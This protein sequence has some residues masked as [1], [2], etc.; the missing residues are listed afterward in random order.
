MCHEHAG[1]TRLERECWSVQPGTLVSRCLRVPS[2]QPLPLAGFCWSWNTAW[3]RTLSSRMCVTSCTVM[4][5]ITSR[6]T[7][8]TSVT[9]PTRKGRTSN[10]CEYTL[11]GLSHPCLGVPQDHTKSHNLVRQVATSNSSMFPE[12]LGDTRKPV[13]YLCSRG[14]F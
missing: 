2:A 14:A 7:S 6:S 12:H 8:P 10:S 11:P 9:R 4:R 13:V 3:R 1:P 5:L